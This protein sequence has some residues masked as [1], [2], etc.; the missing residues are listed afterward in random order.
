[1]K[2]GNFFGYTMA[3][4]N[5]KWYPHG[6]NHLSQINAKLHMQHFS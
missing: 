1:M 6:D 2:Y 3:L 5:P 4:G